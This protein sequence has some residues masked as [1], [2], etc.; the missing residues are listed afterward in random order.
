V[1]SPENSESLTEGRVDAEGE[2][3][4]EENQLNYP[5]LEGEGFPPSLKRTLKKWAA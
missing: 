4:E 2:K 5:H 3:R 1:V